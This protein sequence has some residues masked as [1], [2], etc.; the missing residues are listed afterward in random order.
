MNPLLFITVQVASDTLAAPNMIGEK[1]EET[2]YA[3]ARLI[4]DAVYWV[5]GLFGLSHD[6]SLFI[7]I[8]AS[9][10]FL[11]AWG[12]G[13]LLK[14]IMII[15]FH[16]LSPHVKST[17]YQSLLDNK[18]FI[19]ICRV[20]PAL[21]FIIL[22]QFTLTNRAS[23]SSW[24]TRLS[25]IYVVLNVC[26]S[27]CALATAIWDH[28]NARENTRQLPLS[29]ILQLVKLV[30]WVFGTVVCAG[31]LLDKSPGTLLAGLG[32]FAAVLMLVFKDSIL[33]VVAG[34]QLAQND[35][36][37][38]GDWIA[39]PGSDAN[40]TVVEVGLTAVKI[41]NWDKTVSTV[42]PYSLISGGFKN[43]RF[44]QL[45][46]TRRIQ[47]CYMIDADSV[48]ET[49][50]TLLDEYA[51]IPLL[52]EWIAKKRAQRAAGKTE[53]VRNSEGLADGSIDT[54]L[55]V[56]RGYMKIWLDNNPDIS[57][58]D[59]CF[60]TTLA[61]TS[62]G[63]PFQ[64]YCFTSTSSWI[65][66]EGIMSA[67]FEHIAAMLY[68][69]HLYTIEIASGRDT[70]LDGYLSPGKNP[71]YIHGMPYP[72]FRGSGTPDNPGV[73]PKGIYP[74]MASGAPVP[75]PGATA[76]AVAPD[77]APDTVPPAVQ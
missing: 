77:P 35:S 22:I 34:V 61:Q 25:W 43:Y 1:T 31:I 67:V 16:R 19:K 52:T 69:F 37:H 55:G 26:M 9:L 20:I 12:V 6:S 38:V 66:F 76:A 62:N 17:F 59:D 71:Q 65:P 64:I 36:L 27:L 32:A 48:R 23:L 57:H 13:V 39:V 29:G 44:M 72:F 30:V 14:W 15:S 54:N 50:E 73:P 4:M 58:V 46:N 51:K 68:R 18:F 56:F 40:G 74:G 8:Y 47:R 3:V 49:N 33:G 41:Q 5:L 11:M 42:P 70:I 63:I 45:S 53:N 7:I 28:F 75:P 60:I 10:V 2:S 21:L 24:L